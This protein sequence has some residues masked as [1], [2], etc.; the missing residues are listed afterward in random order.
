MPLRLSAVSL[1]VVLLALAGEARA[2]PSEDEVRYAWLDA[3]LARIEVPTERWFTD[4]A[5]AYATL[6]LADEQLAVITKDPAQ[7]TAAIVGGAGSVLGLLGVALQPNT[8][9]GARERLAAF[10]A[11]TPL[12]KYERRRR[13]EYVLHAVAAE[14]RYWRSPTPHLLALLVS[15]GSTAV[16]IAGYHQTTYGLLN[17]GFGMAIAELQI[18]TRPTLATQAWHRYA[19]TYHPGQP[20]EI[21]PDQVDQ[22]SMSVSLSL[23]GVG[24]RGSF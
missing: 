5:L 6:T 17:L 9:A 11:T 3:E 2:Q 1:S 10:D 7:R 13:A 14:E 21:G 4:W 16:L 18:W 15:G 12:G 23:F 19:N 20:S 22:F 8:L 24:L